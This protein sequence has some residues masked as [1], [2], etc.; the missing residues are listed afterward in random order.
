[1]CI[2]VVGIAAIAAFSPKLPIVSIAI[3]LI[4]PGISVLALPILI[5][6]FWRRVNK[7]GAL[8]GLV[9]GFVSM[10]F[11]IYVLWPE[12]PHNPFYLW[13]GTLPCVTGIVT[14]VVVTLLTPPPPKE[15]IESFYGKG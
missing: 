13:E 15:L 14:L 2:V 9:S 1:M 4:W 7:Q 11:C 12:W 8:A 6:L 10:L 5:M 3:T